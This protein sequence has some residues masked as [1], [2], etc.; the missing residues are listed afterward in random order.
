MTLRLNLSLSPTEFLNYRH[1][2]DTGKLH[3]SFWIQSICLSLG[4]LA[5]QMLL[6]FKHIFSES[7]HSIIMRALITNLK[8][9]AGGQSSS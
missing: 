7:S 1:R 3:K 9:F 6:I 8:Y 2:G 5:S 4:V